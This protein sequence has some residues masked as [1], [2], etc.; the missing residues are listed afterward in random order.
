MEGNSS[1]LQF[2]KYS[3]QSVDIVFAGLYLLVQVFGL[4]GNA[5][6]ITVVRKSRSMYTTTNVLLVNLAVADILTL[7]T[8]PR[9]GYLLAITLDHPKGLGGDILCKFLTGNAIVGIS[10]TVSSVTLTVLALERYRALLRPLNRHLVVSLENVQYVISGIWIMSL[11]VNIPD[12]IENKYS[13][14]FVKCVCPFSLEVVKDSTVHVACTVFFI[15]IVPFLV[16]AFCYTQILRGI[17]FTKEICSQTMNFQ[18]LE[19]KKRLARLL[20]S[21][22]IAFYICYIPYGAYFVYL[23]I[24][25][26]KI[27]IQYYDTHYLLLKLF[28]FLL[29]CSCTLNPILY[30][31]QSSNYRNGFKEACSCCCTRK[32]IRLRT[33]IALVSTRRIGCETGAEIVSFRKQTMKKGEMMEKNKTFSNL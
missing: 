26:R 10:M 13:D 12:F 3:I 7:V 28:E 11:I 24:Q 17:F 32:K 20:L 30:A 25:Q 5:L 14:R 27:I 18:D 33:S 31:F 2:Q 16:L 22:T 8:C 19:N 6:V 4:T 21:V 15:G 23:L 29:V 9:N 1:G